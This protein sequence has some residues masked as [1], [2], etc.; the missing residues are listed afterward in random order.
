MRNIVIVLIGLS[1]FWMLGCQQ[2]IT[3]SVSTNPTATE[4]LSE[5]PNADIFQLDDVVYE[6]NIDWVDDLEVTKYNQIGEIKKTFSMKH[7]LKEFENGD[8]TQ[9]TS[10]TKIFRVKE[11]G[12]VLIV[13]IDG[14]T[15]KYYALV[16]G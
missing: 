8:A 4:I 15:K 10:G 2:E 13:E 6:T 7:P 5:N 1:L 12:D 14:K 11:R 3:H 16:E 9:L